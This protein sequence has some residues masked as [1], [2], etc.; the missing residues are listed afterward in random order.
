MS[1]YT[2]FLRQKIAMA[3]YSGSE[4]SASYFM[5]GCHY[6]RAAEREVSMPSLFDA[7]EDTREEAAA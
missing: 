5:D 2:D 6:L 1:D 3:N 7:V 4:L